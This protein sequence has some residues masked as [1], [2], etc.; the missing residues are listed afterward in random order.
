MRLLCLSISLL[1]AQTSFAV[2]QYSFSAEQ[3]KTFFETKGWPSL[4]VIKGEGVGATGVLKEE[5]GKLSGSLDMDINTF[6][7]GIGLRDEHMKDK[8]LQVKEYPKATVT[9]KEL[10]IPADKKGKVDFLAELE[11]HG[12]KKEV[13]GVAEL[14]PESNNLKVVAEFPIKLSDFKIEI[15]SYKGITVAEDVKV[16]FE[17]L[18]TQKM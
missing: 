1:I 10:A 4:I 12:V 9:L 18:V 3:G 8:Y 11:V 5:S 14:T 13:K 2:S 15:P 6:T 16:K 17:S 7:T